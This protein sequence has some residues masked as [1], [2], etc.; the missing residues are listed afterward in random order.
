[1]NY[2][3]S[4]FFCEAASEQVRG[5]LTLLPRCHQLCHIGFIPSLADRC[6]GCTQPHW[7]SPVSRQRKTRTL[8]A[9]LRWP[10]HTRNNG[11]RLHWWRM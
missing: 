9:R 7:T 6:L 11:K 10:D 8:C 3:E 1:V 2:D 5:A 4:V